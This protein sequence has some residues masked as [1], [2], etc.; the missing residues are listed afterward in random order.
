MPTHNSFGPDD[1]YGIKNA[2]KATIEPNEQGAIGPTQIQ[3]T[4]RAQSKHV[5]LMTQNQNF[6]FKPRSRLEAVAQ[7]MNEKEGDCDHQRG[8]CS[9]SGTAATPADRVFGSD[10]YLAKLR[11]IEYWKKS[12]QLVDAAAVQSEVFEMTHGGRDAWMNWPARV[13]SLIAAEF[14][15][16]QV[17]L[18][19][20]LERHVRQFCVERADPELRYRLRSTN[21]CSRR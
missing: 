21:P 11:Q 12:G 18:T 14:K 13:A 7:H 17:A 20:S 2:R 19:I 3:S 9:D 1:G 6:G 10:T 8:S 4:W 15:I 16:D 5:Q